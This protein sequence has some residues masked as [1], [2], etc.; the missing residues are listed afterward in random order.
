MAAVWILV[1]A[2]NA[3]A[4]NQGRIRLAAYIVIVGA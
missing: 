4:A 1:E 3:S 2:L